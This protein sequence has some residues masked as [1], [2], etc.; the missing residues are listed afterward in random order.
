MRKLRSSPYLFLPITNAHVPSRALS[1]SFWPYSQN[2]GHERIGATCAYQDLVDTIP[3]TA[4][5]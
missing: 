1:F 3:F 5:P 4:A 2:Y